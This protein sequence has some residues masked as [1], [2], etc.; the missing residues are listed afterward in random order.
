[1]FLVLSKPQYPY[2]IQTQYNIWDIK[3]IPINNSLQNILL[4][5]DMQKYFTSTLSVAVET[6]NSEIMVGL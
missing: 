3:F 6:C 5:R 2:I 1:M 4:I